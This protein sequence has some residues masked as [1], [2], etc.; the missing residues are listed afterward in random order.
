MP[1]HRLANRPLSLTHR[2]PKISENLSKSIG[3]IAR[4]FAPI[5]MDIYGGPHHVSSVRTNLRALHN[6][7]VIHL[8]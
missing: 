8:T 1:G 3:I 2:Y 5:A 4:F 7:A 6:L